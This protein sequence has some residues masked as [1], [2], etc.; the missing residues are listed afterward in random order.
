MCK[1]LFKVKSERKIKGVDV[2]SYF[3]QQSILAKGIAVCF[4]IFILASCGKNT[5]DSMFQTSESAVNAYRTYLSDMRSMETLST[6]HLIE[7]INGWQALRDSVFVRIA[8]DTANCIHANYESEIRGLHDSLRIEFTR[9]ALEKSRTFADVLLIKE[10]TSQYRQD[11]E[12]MQSAAEAEPFFKPLDSVPTYK[13]SANAVV[14]KYRMFLSKTLKSGISGKSEML[15]FI[16]EEDRLFRS[17]LSH[18]P[19]LADA[20]LSAITRD[21]E[22]CCLSV[23]QSAEDGKISYRDALI[24][25]ARRTNRRIILNALACRNDINQ[26]NVKT[27]AQARAYVWMLLQPYVALDG[28]SMAVLSDMERTTLHAVADRTPQMIAKLNKTAGTDN[29]QWRV[30]PGVLIK[31]MLTSI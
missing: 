15:A 24:Y 6:E 19:E 23:F 8:K 2:I 22:K 12:L 13:G 14:E 27:E 4:A 20:D 28:F 9:L 7:A 30:L 25:T 29:D 31:I 16:K 18:L 5:D 11:T 10:K 26:G 21:T 3:K 17:F 1:G